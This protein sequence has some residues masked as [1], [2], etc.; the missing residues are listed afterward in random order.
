M[1]YKRQATMKNGI[2]IK[3]RMNPIIASIILPQA[4]STFDIKIYGTMI[5]VKKMRKNG[6]I[7]IPNTIKPIVRKN[8]A[9]LP[10]SSCNAN[11]LTP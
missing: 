6:Q 7:R 11:L 9:H 1:K 2:I 4:E 10:L 8:E 5:G 3:P